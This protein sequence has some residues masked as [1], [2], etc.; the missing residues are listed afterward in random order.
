M[1]ALQPR[2]DA[3][4]S[5]M[6]DALSWL[7]SLPDSATGEAEEAGGCKAT[8][9]TDE[10]GP[11]AADGNAG[12]DGCGGTVTDDAV[13]ELVAMGFARDEVVAALD[14]SAGDP[15]EAL[16]ALSSAASAKRRRL[17][18][19][20]VAAPDSAGEDVEVEG[21]QCSLT[22]AGHLALRLPK[23]GGSLGPVVGRKRGDGGVT[24][25][26]MDEWLWELYDS[27]KPRPV[28]LPATFSIEAVAASLD[29]GAAYVWDAFAE[30]EE[31][32]KA[33]LELELAEQQEARKEKAKLQKAKKAQKK[34]EALK[35]A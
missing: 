30:P 9:E 34:E 10:V 7:C 8:S 3:S 31:I 28:P 2:S 23:D 5:E 16:A 20:S 35:N 21:V 32:R 15:D 29:R 14:A 12:I 6:D 25:D 1:P 19:T 27:H 22:S 24:F 17:E 18:A 13:A 11:A 26:G 33:H 4:Q